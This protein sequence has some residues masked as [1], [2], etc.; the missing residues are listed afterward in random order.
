VPATLPV[1]TAR[2]REVTAH[3]ALTVGSDCNTGKMTVAWELV[4]ALKARGVA[5]AFV[6]TGQTGVLLEGR[7]LA[8]D[9][10]VSDFVAGAAE[11]LVLDAAPGHDWVVVEGQG[12]LIHPGYSGVTLGLLHGALPHAMIL[13]HQPSRTEIRHGGIP[14]PPLPEL[15]RRYEDALAPL[16]PG[17]VVAVALNTYDLDAAAARRA[18]DDAQAATGLPAT[19][20]VR[21]GTG[22]LVDALLA[23]APTPGGPRP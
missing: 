3:V 2:V 9:R 10:V 5:A 1:A 20:P 7:G 21:F 8:V 6:A 23:F 12:S 13:C 4:R 19:D 11:L 14:I 22:P 16:R 15:V 17:R 18:I